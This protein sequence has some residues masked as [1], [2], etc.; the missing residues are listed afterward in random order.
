MA[1]ASQGNKSPITLQKF[2]KGADYPASRD[3][4][5]ELAENNGAEEEVLDIIGKLPDVD[6]ESVADVQEAFGDVMEFDGDKGD[7]GNKGNGSNRIESLV[8]EVE[9]NRS[10]TRPSRRRQD[11]EEEGRGRSESRRGNHDDHHDDEIEMHRRHY[12]ERKRLRMESQKADDDEW[13]HRLKGHETRKMSDAR[14]MVNGD[15]GRGRVTNPKTDKRLAET[16]TP[17]LRDARHMAHVKEGETDGR[18]RVRKFG[19]GELDERINREDERPRR[20]NN[21]PDPETGAMSH[22]RKDDN[23]QLRDEYQTAEERHKRMTYRQH[24][25]RGR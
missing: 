13:D 20:R 7:K 12:E 14:H 24:K 18:G 9:Q 17:A 23:G 25:D 6:F 2:L 8:R 19:P 15:D 4:L 1:R 5:Y 3:E 16:E 10:D 21:E 11:D 22:R